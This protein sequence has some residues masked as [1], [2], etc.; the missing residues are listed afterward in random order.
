MY[1]VQLLEFRDGKVAGE[2]IYGGKPGRP[3]S[4]EPPGARTLQQLRCSE[5]LTSSSVPGIGRGAFQD[6]LQLTAQRYF[7]P[8]L[9]TPRGTA[10]ARL[11]R[12][13]RG[14]LFARSSR[15]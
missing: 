15:R 3:P 2:R 12:G 9:A 5:T 13:D 7:R 4:G 11:P 1:G 10:L 6:L 14:R 8:C